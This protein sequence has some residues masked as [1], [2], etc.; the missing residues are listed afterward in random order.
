M[1]IVFP[2]NPVNGQIYPD[3]ALP[4]V[5]QWQWD[6]PKELWKEY[7]L[8]VKLRTGNYNK[9]S[10]PN[11]DGI[12]GEQLT[13]DG[14]GNLSWA[15]STAPE[16]QLIGLLEPFNGTLK[17][18]TLVIQGTQVPYSPVPANNIVV[19]VGGIPQTPT[20]SYTINNFVI[21]FTEAPLNGASFYAF[22]SSYTSPTSIKPEVKP[23]QPILKGK[24]KN[25][26]TPSK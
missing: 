6:A 18:F 8:Y 11:D 25:K 2:I 3:P 19:F 4:G 20:L 12:T 21:S 24:I 5:G 15:P 16:L 17:D 26:I 13:T 22:S 23:S 10:W 7:P 9:Y 1:A 14:N